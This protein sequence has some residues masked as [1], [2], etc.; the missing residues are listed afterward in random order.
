MTGGGIGTPAARRDGD[1]RSSRSDRGG[2]ARVLAGAFGG[3]P[4]ASRRSGR[5]DHA[6]FGRAAGLKCVAEYD[7][8]EWLAAVQCFS[9]FRNGAAAPG[10]SGSASG[11]LAP[12][13]LPAGYVRYAD[14]TGFSIGIPAGWQVSHSGGL[15]Y[16]RPPAGGMFL[17]IQQTTR[18]QSNALADWKQQAA[19][20][21][22]TYPGYHQIR[23]QSV[24][25]AEAEQAAAWEFTY[26]L[27][28]VPTHVLNLNVLV[29][30]H[31]AYALYWSAPQSQW[32]ASYHYFTE[33]MASFRPASAPATAVSGS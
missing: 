1:G 4:A 20:R 7:T 32:A 27:D 24:S 16:F 19:A 25:Y 29:N 9:L 33:F 23:I 15:V 8:C 30:S 13:V 5:V 6:Q 26:N 14:P 22:G 28:G 17:F 2:G 3:Q 18:P 12:A 21:V 10:S 11:A 31:Q